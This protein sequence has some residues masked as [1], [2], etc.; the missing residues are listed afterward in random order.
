MYRK[1]NVC[2]SSMIMETLRI[3]QLHDTLTNLSA[4]QCI[5]GFKT[6]QGLKPQQPGSPWYNTVLKGIAIQAYYCL[7]RNTSTF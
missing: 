4:F 2:V 6:I 5:K 1:P 7:K 3:R